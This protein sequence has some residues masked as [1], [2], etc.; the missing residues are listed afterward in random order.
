MTSGRKIKKL[1]KED[2]TEESDKILRNTWRHLGRNFLHNTSG[3]TKAS[4]KETSRY[5]KS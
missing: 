4:S 2:L 5:L 3:P 1:T